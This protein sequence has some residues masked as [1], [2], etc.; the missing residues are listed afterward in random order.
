MVRSSIGRWDL[1][2]FKQ[3]HEL[4]PLPHGS[5]S[6]EPPGLPEGAE[7]SQP[8]WGP[9]GVLDTVSGGGA[10][11]WENSPEYQWGRRAEGSLRLTQTLT[12]KT[13]SSGTGRKTQPT[14]G[15]CHP[16][17]R[18]PQGRLRKRSL[19]R[20]PGAWAPR[21][22]QLSIRQPDS[23]GGPGPGPGPGPGQQ[24]GASRGRRLLSRCPR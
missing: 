7:A 5:R 16:V 20:Q 1:G 6:P 8:A 13:E 17:C 22:S 15:K 11:R 14:A 18:E 24:P 23:Q 19:G 4:S 3:P 12:M 9:A 21:P 2:T 10:S